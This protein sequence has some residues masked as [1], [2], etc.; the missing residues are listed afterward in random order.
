MNF[1]ITKRFEKEF[2]LLSKGTNLASS[3]NAVI[4]N[5]LSARKISDIKNI[6]KLSGYKIYY[7]IRV[8][9]YRAGIKIEN[10]T[11]IFAVFDYRKDIYKKSP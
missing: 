4:D 11:V 6:K 1:E 10:D 8:G 3:L 5:V 9:K 7:R 2:K